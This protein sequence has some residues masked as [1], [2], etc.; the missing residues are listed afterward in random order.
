[1]ANKS[2]RT[3]KPA[4]EDNIPD[5]RLS[6]KAINR[7]EFGRRLQQKILSKGWRQSDLARATGIGKDSIS[8]YIR[9]RSL[10]SP[11][12]LDSMAKALGVSVTDLL[13]NAPAAAMDE[14]LPAIELR[15]A[16]GHPELVWL[17]VNRAMSFATAAKI[18]DLLRADD[19]LR[20]S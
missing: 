18:I 7:K 15:Q 16:A 12:A 6:Q 11:K 5:R 14:E 4:I 2:T 13:P 3:M 20:K 1:M 19:E 8:H 17:R 9:G 10:P